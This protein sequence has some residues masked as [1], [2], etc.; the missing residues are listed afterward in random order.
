MTGAFYSFGKSNW[1]RF[2][3]LD[4]AEVS[5]CT[6]RDTL[7]HWLGNEVKDPDTQS[8]MERELA[9]VEVKAGRI[10]YACCT[11]IRVKAVLDSHANSY[12]VVR[13]WL[14]C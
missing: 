11:N 8:C 6:R 13:G 1:H 12:T 4:A 14:R 5:E 9:P 7:P 3:D 10:V 2:T